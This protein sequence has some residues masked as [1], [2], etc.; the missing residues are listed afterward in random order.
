MRQYS[1]NPSWRCCLPGN[2]ESRMFCV[3]FTLSQSL[4]TDYICE[5]FS[6]YGRLSESRQTLYEGMAPTRNIYAIRRITS[7]K[8]TLKAYILSA[9]SSS[10]SAFV[11]SKTHV[12]AQK[13]RGR[14]LNK[15][16]CTVAKVKFFI[17]FVTALCSNNDNLKT[18]QVIT[19]FLSQ[20]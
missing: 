1:Q 14:Q 17:F 20:N 16:K 13:P 5:F 8:N 7:P 12:S 4:F 3:S 10:F 15:K 2:S 6:Q 11:I 9:Q 18:V 19:V